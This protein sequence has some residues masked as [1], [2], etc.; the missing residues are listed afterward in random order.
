MISEVTG[1][2]VNDPPTPTGIIATAARGSDAEDGN[3]P[4]PAEDRPEVEAATPPGR[5]RMP[6]VT[7][8]GVYV[9]IP[10]VKPVWDLL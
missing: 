4:S 7:V 6:C 5:P 1:G 8:T 10:T 2:T 3:S 9:L